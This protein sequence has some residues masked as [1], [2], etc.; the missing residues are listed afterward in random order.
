MPDVD[1]ASEQ[2]LHFIERNH[3]WPIARRVCRIGMCLEKQTVRARGERRKRERR[4]HLAHAATAATLAFPRLL[5][6]VRAVEHDR[7]ARGL[8]ESRKIPHV[9]DEIAVAKESAALG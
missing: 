6:G 4:N 5:H 7:T 2:L 3:V 9:D 1:C 8:L